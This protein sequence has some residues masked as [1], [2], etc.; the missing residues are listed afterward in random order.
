MNLDEAIRISRARQKSRFSAVDL[1]EHE[2]DRAG[3][4]ATVVPS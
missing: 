2:V 3:S 1:T 4:S